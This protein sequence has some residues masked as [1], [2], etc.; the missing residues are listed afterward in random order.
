MALKP[1]A[2]LAHEA[3]WHPVG[4][5]QHIEATEAV[6]GFGAVFKA[7]VSFLQKQRLELGIAL[8]FDDRPRMLVAKI[9]TW[10]GDFDAQRMSFDAKG[11]AG[12]RCCLLCRNVLKRNSG[13]SEIDPTFVE[14]DCC[15]PELFIPQSD[16]DIFSL[17]DDLLLAQRTQSKKN[18]RNKKNFLDL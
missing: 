1:L 18:G 17:Y 12:L 11:S 6:G 14:V 5:I 15:K 13:V 8:S 3:A 2:H 4:F 7:F 9:T 10:I 16:S